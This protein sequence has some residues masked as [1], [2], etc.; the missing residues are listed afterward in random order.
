MQLLIISKN[1][2]DSITEN[3]QNHPLGI[4]HNLD[5]LSKIFGE[6][7]HQEPRT[8][9]FQPVYAYTLCSS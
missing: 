6:K 3:F 2:F 5:P 7:K 4:Y 1:K 8:L 9:D